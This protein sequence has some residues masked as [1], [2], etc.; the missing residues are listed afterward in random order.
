MLCVRGVHVCIWVFEVCVC[1]CVWMCACTFLDVCLCVCELCIWGQQADRQ[2]TCM[3]MYTMYM[4]HKYK[5]IGSLVWP[6]AHAWHIMH[7]TSLLKIFGVK[8]EIEIILIPTRTRQGVNN[9][10]RRTKEIAYKHRLPHSPQDS[11]ERQELCVNFGLAQRMDTIS[12]IANTRYEFQLIIL[13]LLR[14][15]FNSQW[16]YG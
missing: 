12:T 16:S 14:D 4:S 9:W 13:L 5:S 2:A 11:R 10:I 8:S 3:H 6:T 7:H 1:V 15:S